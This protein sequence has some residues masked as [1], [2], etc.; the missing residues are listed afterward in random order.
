[1][2]EKKASEREFITEHGMKTSKEAN[3]SQIQT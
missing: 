1:V 3:N 2:S